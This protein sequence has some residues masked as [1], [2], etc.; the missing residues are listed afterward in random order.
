MEQQNDKYRPVLKIDLSK[1]SSLK[2]ADDVAGIS[3]GN[4]LDVDADPRDL[5]A[6]AGQLEKMK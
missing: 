3:E 1:S 5:D 4:V 2:S 6:L